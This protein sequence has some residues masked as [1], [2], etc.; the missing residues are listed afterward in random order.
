MQKTTCTIIAGVNGA[1]KTTFA[2]LYLPQVIGCRN[3]ANAD[4]I[5]AGL[6]MTAL[7]KQ[8][9]LAKEALILAVIDELDKKND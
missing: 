2:M 8:A 4:L 7:Q 6:N 1:G 9:N 3:F 5:A